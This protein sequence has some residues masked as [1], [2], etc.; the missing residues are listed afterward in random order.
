MPPCP[1]EIVNR[2]IGC[3]IVMKCIPPNRQNS[4]S[5][6]R[7]FGHD[8]SDRSTIPIRQEILYP[9]HHIVC[10]RAPRNIKWKS[11]TIPL[12]FTIAAALFTQHAIAQDVEELFGFASVVYAGV[13]FKCK[14]DMIKD[15]ASF[16]QEIDCMR[17]DGTPAVKTI[18]GFAGMLTYS[19]PRPSL[20]VSVRRRYK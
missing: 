17:P 8:T 7:D 6:R 16:I 15:C 9:A 13:R 14:G 4:R 12:D 18:H 3:F 5:Y 10:Y 1:I 11:D 20:T 2:R 19:R